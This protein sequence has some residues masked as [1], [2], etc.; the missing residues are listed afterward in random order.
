MDLIVSISAGLICYVFARNCEKALKDA[1]GEEPED[2]YSIIS[3]HYSIDQDFLASESGESNL[4]FN[5]II[6]LYLNSISLLKANRLQ[7]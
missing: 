7:S 1:A 6:Y 2:V 5:V 3:Y 4:F